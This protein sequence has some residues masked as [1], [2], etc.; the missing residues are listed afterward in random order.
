MSV[1]RT[2]E[3]E[4]R[5]PERRAFDLEERELAD[6]IGSRQA[7][8]IV[9][10]RIRQ[11]YGAKIEAYA[12]ERLD[13]LGIRYIDG[14]E[15]EKTLDAA[16]ALCAAA[17]Q[18]GLPRD[19][20][21]VGVGGGVVLDVT[22][23]AAAM[24]RR[25]IPYVRVPTTLVGLIDVSV[26]IKHG[27]NFAGKKNLLGAFYP[28]L[29]SINDKSFL[30][31]L[32]RRHIACGLAEIAKIGLACDAKLFSLIER[33]GATLLESGFRTPAEIADEVLLRAECAMMKE[34]APNLFETTLRRPAD[35]GH[36]FS[37]MLEVASDY[38]LAHGEAVALDMLVSTALAVARGICDPCVL[39]RLLAFYRSVGLPAAHPLL[40]PALLCR[41]I[42]ETRAHRGGHLNLV[43][44]AA[45]GA[46]AFIQAVEADELGCA[47]AS[48]AMPSS[49][50]GE[51]GLHRR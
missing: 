12:R 4:V 15:G 31:T 7:L 22:G 23:F 34:L 21:L 28:P 40:T 33:F 19:G 20:V 44:P 2:I 17:A 26:G 46:T 41:A 25:G 10:E 18:A 27:V 42:V 14:S 49:E 32:P 9:D 37:P 6:L 16:A 51:Y 45:V 5:H 38:A 48:L 29:G 11:R 36:T 50:R 47:I 24:Y 30:A 13:A 8:L 35:F 1:T 39:A 3:Y 43:V